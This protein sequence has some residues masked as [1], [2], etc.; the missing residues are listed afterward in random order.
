MTSPREQA[1][2]KIAV[3]RR[4]LHDYF[5]VDRTEAGIELRG[6]E[7]KSIRSGHI[8]LVGAYARVESGVPVLFNVNIPPYEHGN[9]FNHVPD[10]PRRLL[11]HR[12]EIRRLESQSELQGHALIPLSVYFKHGFLKVELGVCKGKRQADK[13]ETIRRRDADLEAR[14]AM[15]A[16]RR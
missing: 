3:N 10:R 6:T 7:V 16:A 5:V 12:K 14:R 1:F 13:R 2:R 9:R 15:A 11:C 4:A 8:S